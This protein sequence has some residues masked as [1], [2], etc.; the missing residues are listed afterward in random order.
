MTRVGAAGDGAAMSGSLGWRLVVVGGGEVLLNQR[1]I[2]VDLSRSDLAAG[3]PLHMQ[4]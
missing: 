2:S 4:S 1:D 3:E